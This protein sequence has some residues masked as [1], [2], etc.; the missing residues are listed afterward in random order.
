MDQKPLD[1]SQEKENR[2]LVFDV[3]TKY[4]Q[5]DYGYPVLFKHIFLYA[6]KKLKNKDIEKRKEQ[7]ISEEERILRLLKEYSR[8]KR[9]K[10]A[11]VYLK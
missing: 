9:T 3:L 8:K 6:L 4:N 2:D 1:L 11:N 10:L 7:S 5:K